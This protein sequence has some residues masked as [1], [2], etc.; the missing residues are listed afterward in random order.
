MRRLRAEACPG[1]CKVFGPQGH[2][3]VRNQAARA[4][5]GTLGARAKLPFV[6]TVLASLRWPTWVRWMFASTG[7]APLGAG[8][9][10][11]RPVRTSI[12]VAVA[13]A[14]AVAWPSGVGQALERIEGFIT[15]ATPFPPI[16]AQA[17]GDVPAGAGT[18][19]KLLPF[20][21][22]P[23]NFAVI[24]GSALTPVLVR[25]GEFDF[26]TEIKCQRSAAVLGAW[27][28]GAFDRRRAEFRLHGGGHAD[29]GGNE[30]Y[31]FEFSTLK[32]ARET[33]PHPLTGPFLRDTDGDGVADACPAPAAGPP[34][35]HTYQGFLYVPKI[36]RYWLFGTGEYCRDGMGGSSAWEYDANNKTWTAMPE[37]SKLARF[38]RAVV[39]SASGNVLIHVGRVS[40]WREIDP[41]TR[42]I[43]RSFEKDSFGRYIDGPA[44][45]DQQRRVLYALID[46][47]NTDRLVAYDWPAP[48]ES[49]GFGGRLIAEWPKEG[50]KGWGMAQHASGLLVL[51]NGLTQIIAV[52][53]D[54]GKSWEEAAGSGDVS[55]SASQK[56]GKIYS[57]WSYIPDVDAFFGITNADLGVVLYRLD[58]SAAETRKRSSNSKISDGTSH[59]DRPKDAPKARSPDSPPPVAPLA[60]A[61]TQVAAAPPN[62]SQV[63]PREIETAASWEEICAAA[64]LC[65]PMG[66]GAVIYRGRVVEDGPPKRGRSWRSIGQDATHPEAEVSRPDPEVGGLRFTFP[67]K[68]G[69]G[70]AGNF[71]T[72]FSPDY[73]FQIGPADAGAPA[74][75]AYIQ[76]QVRYSC[77]FIWTDCD[78]QSP[79]YRKLRRCFLSKGGDG[80]CTAS[81]IALISTGDRDG[82]RADACTRIQTAINHRTDH[83]LHAFHRCPRVQGFGVSLPRVGGRAQGDSQPNGAYYCP[84]VLSD[85]SGS[86]W[87]NTADSCFRLIDDRW[88]TIQI[89]LRFGP[90]QAKQKKND[91]RL[92][93]VSIWAAIEGENGG[94]QKLIIDN[95]F[96][97]SVPETTKDFVGK[98]WLMPHL[99]EKTNTEEHPPFYVW[100][101]NL[102]V[103]ESMISNPR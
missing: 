59:A 39:D 93:H 65:D 102:I 87:N 92:S 89:H 66:E 15:P 50:K 48:G 47:R 75:E 40:G 103:S 17:E 25:D 36:D 69:S 9:A 38:A 90:W 12:R 14:A 35:T 10:A 63:A 42:R 24:P 27:N 83:T 34:A 62:S 21:P 61:S 77:T 53:P 46:G 23:G 18:W 70:A 52:D 97:A 64:V 6:K 41:V 16:I 81:K 82:F 31:V 7:Q 60:T 55:V 58:G 57:K 91:T 54:S 99:Y 94:R 85:G 100:Y 88:I 56:A 11:R 80:A 68:S 78:P 79:N 37:F 74:Q 3:R 73:S 20:L 49:T 29:Y 51:W 30:M 84:R 98:I 101:R 32:W 28:G 2:E 26:C 67:S 96:A 86:R 72:N 44:V 95:D 13:A 33:D 45:F 71:K 43:V 1:L 76:F 22:R 5:G 8:I 19:K 4:V